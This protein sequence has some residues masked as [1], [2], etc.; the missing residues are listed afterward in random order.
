LFGIEFTVNCFYE[1]YVYSLLDWLINSRPGAGPNMGRS[2]AHTLFTNFLLSTPKTRF[3]CLY[4]DLNKYR[5]ST[6]GHRRPKEASW[7]R[8]RGDPKAAEGATRRRLR[9]TW[10]RLRARESDAETVDGGWGRLI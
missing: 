10:R 6:S 9:A 3:E 1:F 7:R 5:G 2:L 8:P 4:F